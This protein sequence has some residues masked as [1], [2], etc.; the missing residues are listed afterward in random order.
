MLAGV[1]LGTIFQVASMLWGRKS[2][3]AFVCMSE[4]LHR[5]HGTLALFDTQLSTVRFIT[6][7]AKRKGRVGRT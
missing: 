6:L 5:L 1:S 2:V 7:E 3:C 4:C